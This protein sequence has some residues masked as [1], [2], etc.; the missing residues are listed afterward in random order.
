MNVWS[1]SNVR[2]VIMSRVS[3][4]FMFARPVLCSGSVPG[5]ICP[6]QSLVSM[7]EVACHLSNCQQQLQ[8][9]T[10]SL[11]LGGG[12]CCSKR[13]PWVGNQHWRCRCGTVAMASGQLLSMVCQ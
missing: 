2:L 11:F 8:Q 9:L 4:L 7:L 13:L 3:M 6:A 5:V 12:L 1:T 10:V